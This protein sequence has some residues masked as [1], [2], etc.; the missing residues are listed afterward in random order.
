MGEDTRGRRGYRIEAT[1]AGTLGVGFVGATIA[2]GTVPTTLLDYFLPG[3]QPLSTLDPMLSVGECMVC[4]GNF[5][6]QTEPFRP[7]AASMMGQSA[8]D[9]VFHAALELA[10]HDAAF[11]GDLCLRCH[12]PVGWIE[13]RSTPTTGA[14][15]TGLDFEGVAC[16]FC[17]RMVDPNYQPGISPEEDLE[18]IQALGAVPP[19]PHSGTFVVDPLDRRRGPYDLGPNFPPYHEWIQSPFHE[20]SNMCATC[21]DVSNP[22]WERQ[23]NGTY[24]L[25]PL[26]T[27]QATGS[28]YD[29]FPVERTY[30]EWSQSE[31]AQ[32]PVNVGGRFGG[33]LTAVSSCQ[34]CH[35]PPT[36]G[37][38][39]RQGD[40]RSDLPTHYFNGGNTWV[41]RAIRNLY[42][43][44]ETHLSEDSVNASIARA[45]DMLEKASDME[46]SIVSGQLRVRIINQTGHKL[47]T[48]YPEGRRM[49]LNVKF[50]DGANNV[51]A[52]RGAYN[53][54]TAVLVTGDTKVYEAKLG[55]DAAGSA[56]TGLPV[57]ETFHF[58]LNNHWIKDNRIPPRGFTNAGFESVQAAPVAYTYADGQHWD[59]TLFS[60]PA[61]AASA[62]V[63]LNYQTTSKE[64]IEFLRDYA[65]PG[66]TA[67]QIAYDQW[68]LT[69]K[70]APTVMDAASITLPCYA[71]CDG[72]TIAPVLNVQDFACFLNA[73][74]ANDPYANCDGSTVVPVLNVQDFACFLNKFA[75]GC[76]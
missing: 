58:V 11:S 14:A 71:N 57:G 5:D 60:I 12:T 45:A 16:H 6:A 76:P 52:E 47:P 61:G 35:M 41:L 27:P 66:G 20:S 46:L 67:G 40:P 50:L 38:G 19:N 2:L 30:S 23:P 1:W 63:S 15:L 49:W 28:K 24:T 72:S 17:H 74:A 56:A 13:G 68:A 32:G 53:A 48:G 44:T 31:F 3:S 70:S 34:D 26:D 64:Y 62:T 29:Q 65:P 42:P 39:C 22:V 43:D 36:T 9:P 75:Q 25:G 54:A 8:R 7:W 37:R 21:H 73:F 4:H 10:N 59:D 69:G 18:I 33:N 51:V 55:V